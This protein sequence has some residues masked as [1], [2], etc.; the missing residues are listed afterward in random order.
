MS[1]LPASVPIVPEETFSVTLPISKLQETLKEIGLHHGVVAVNITTEASP[2]FE[3]LQ[4]AMGE[5]A[6][7]VMELEEGLE[8]RAMC[9]ASITKLRDIVLGP[10]E[11]HLKESLDAAVKN[12]ETV[13]EETTPTFARLFKLFD[14]AMGKVE[15]E[16]S[17]L[18]ES[19]KEAPRLKVLEAKV[20][21]L[22]YLVKYTER[23]DKVWNNPEWLAQFEETFLRRI[24]GSGHVQ[25]LITVKKKKQSEKKASDDKASET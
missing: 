21:E 5:A 7:R 1:G 13:V 24:K 19:G 22:R 12:Y 4:A 10:E 25:D 17:V 6:F 20:D 16:W 18:Y 3:A 8:H 15:K 2:M 9:K 11:A 14:E 23:K